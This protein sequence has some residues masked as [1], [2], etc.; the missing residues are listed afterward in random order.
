MNLISPRPFGARTMQSFWKSSANTI[1]TGSFIARIA[2][3]R[4]IWLLRKTRLC[5]ISDKLEPQWVIELLCLRGFYEIMFRAPVLD[6]AIIG[7]TKR[8]NSLEQDVIL[9]ARM[10]ACILDY[11]RFTHNS[12]Q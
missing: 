10:P 6:G 1:Q 9:R 12:Q 7:L 5:V 4:K 3:E 8:S 11:D 2:L